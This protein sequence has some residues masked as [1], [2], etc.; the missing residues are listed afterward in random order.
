MSTTRVTK[1]FLTE[2]LDAANARI[3]VLEAQCAEAK[4]PVA[5]PARTFTRWA[6]TQSSIDA[7]AAF[8]AKC[9]AAKLL[10]ART[11]RSVIA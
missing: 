1:A 9:N 5:M 2:A 10:A 3:A 8:I 7:H 4:R 11:G 6:P